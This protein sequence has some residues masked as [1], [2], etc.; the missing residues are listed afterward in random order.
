MTAA[1]QTVDG[2]QQPTS[3]EGRQQ[4]FDARRHARS[5]VEQIGRDVLVIGQQQK[6]NGEVAGN[7][8]ADHEIGAEIVDDA[9]VH[10]RTE[11]VAHVSPQIGVG[12]DDGY[13]NRRR[14]RRRRW[15]G[16]AGGV[17]VGEQ[18][19]LERDSRRR[20]RLS[21]LRLRWP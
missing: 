13:A 3:V 1:E 4:D 6:W 2:F 17:G 16:P 18:R 15:R 14:P 11:A 19:H 12:Y 20:R 5:T 21:G 10:A 8:I 7:S 9:K